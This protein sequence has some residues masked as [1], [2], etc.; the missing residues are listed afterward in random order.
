MRIKRKKILYAVFLFITVLMFLN[1]W[2][3]YV[4]PT[5]SGAN[6]FAKKHHHHNHH[7]HQLY[8]TKS[9]VLHS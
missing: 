3:S 6:M 7:Y 9:T 5:N 8:N 1:G 2:K 4:T